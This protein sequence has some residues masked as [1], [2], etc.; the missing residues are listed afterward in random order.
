MT[1][2]RFV[3]FTYFCSCRDNCSDNTTELSYRYE[4][5]VFPA[6]TGKNSDP[7][8]RISGPNEVYET[9]GI[10]L[11]ADASESHNDNLTYKWH[12]NGGIDMGSTGNMISLLD[13]TAPDVDA[14]SRIIISSASYR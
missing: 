6:I 13:P 1:E 10:T 4:K 14:N 8:A 3:Y 5:F 7:I 11:R 9:D 12:Y 2:I